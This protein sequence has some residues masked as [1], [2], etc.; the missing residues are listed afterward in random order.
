[1]TQDTR[2]DPRAKIVSLNVRY[3]SATVDEFIENH[4]HDVSK[5]GI[6]IKTST[7]FPQ[8]TLLK[9]EIRLSGDQAV[10][11]GV[12]RVVWKREANT[13][14]SESPA[15][16]GVKFIKIDENS[17]AVIDRLVGAKENAGIA[18]TSE[19]EKKS[20]EAAPAAAAAALNSTLIG[21]GAPASSTSAPPRAGGPTPKSTILGMGAV[22][23]ATPAPGT[24][25][26]AAVAGFF[27]ATNSQADMPPPEERT[28]MKQA[29]ELLEEALKGAG[30]SMDEIG[31]NPLF[32]GPAAG[33]AKTGSAATPEAKKDQDAAPPPS[34]VRDTPI[35]KESAPGPISKPAASA[36]ASVKPAA[37]PVAAV[38][39]ASEPT[40]P[41]PTKKFPAW[42][43]VP[44]LLVIAGGLAFALKPDL[45]GGGSTA[46]PTPTPTPSA[47]V[48]VAPVTSIAPTAAVDAATA[49]V[50]DAS[51]L[52][53]VGANDAAA[54]KDS[55]PATT[56]V[57]TPPVAPPVVKPPPPPP[58]VVTPKPPK[59]ADPPP[60]EETTT[61]PPP[62]PVPKPPPPPKKPADD[63]DNPY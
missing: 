63:S 33:A 18:F 7:P 24:V 46:V 5:G 47:P 29:A 60:G 4:S 57:V 58:P 55:G 19:L 41:I 45:F 28:M 14:G 13:S 36:P 40:P 8:G 23:D 37:R 39:R 51:A 32:A 9:F 43:W 17:R 27:P 21:T 44:I 30:G 6:F 15:G 22:K 59:P 50:S 16:M 48:S 11:A 26:P 52:G 12:G 25:T 56:A 54:A 38:A 42:A 34:T 20:D 10:I 2:K 35:A 61:T 49:A 1:M 31:T 53:V 3:K 62:K